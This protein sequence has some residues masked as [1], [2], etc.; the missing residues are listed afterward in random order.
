MKPELR[1]EPVP[2]K[3]PGT[4]V[5]D[6]PAMSLPRRAAL[7]AAMLALAVSLTGCG[8]FCGAAG[9]SGGGVAAGCGTGI[10]F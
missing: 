1:T 3:H 7:A 10:R 6:T 2:T 5:T 9:G 4:L 8:V